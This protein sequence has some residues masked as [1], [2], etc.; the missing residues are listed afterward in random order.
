MSNPPVLQSSDDESEENGKETGDADFRRPPRRSGPVVTRR[1]IEI[2]RWIGRHGLVTAQQVARRFFYRGDN[3]IG[4]W[5]CYRRLRALAEMA[6]LR[7]DRTFWRE[8]SVLRLTTA[9]ARFADVEVHPAHLVLAEVRHSL[10][11][12]DLLEE[13]LRRSPW[14]TTFVTERELRAERLRERH[15]NPGASGYGRLPDAEL[16]LP[17]RQRIAV[18][19]DLTPKRSA[20][21]QEILTSYLSQDYEAIWWYV[22]P[23]VVPRLR[24]IVV[25]LQADDIVS[26]QGWSS[27]KTARP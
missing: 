9:G 3:T 23:G 4:V 15:R 24:Q 16:R 6:L 13:L 18:E 11:V 22:P 10:A 17:H 7:R 19:L 8:P 27:D 1:D 26:V 21:Y 12:V 25:D 2:L 5:S 14:G 20:D